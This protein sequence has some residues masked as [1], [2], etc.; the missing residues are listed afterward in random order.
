MNEVLVSIKTEVPITIFELPQVKEKVKPLFKKMESEIKARFDEIKTFILD[1]RNNKEKY[2][3]IS[4]DEVVKVFK[5]YF[6]KSI[7]NAVVKI[8]FSDKGKYDV[9]DNILSLLTEEK[10]KD[11]ILGKPMIDSFKYVIRKLPHDDCLGTC[12][13]GS[14]IILL[15]KEFLGRKIPY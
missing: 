5:I 3:A 8:T 15:E 11:A 13:N 7:L 9:V 4:Y 12:L 6:Y 1:R 14:T 2:E 10:L